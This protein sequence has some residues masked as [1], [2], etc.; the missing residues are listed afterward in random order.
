MPRLIDHDERRQ[1]FAEATWRVILRDGVGKVSVRTVAAEAGHSAGSLRHVFASQ[2]ELLVFALQLVV[3]RAEERVDSLREVP[4]PFE[5]VQA[6][7]AQLLPLDAQ[8]RAEMEVYLALFTAAN[9]DADLRPARDVAHQSVLAGC[10]W[11]I[12]Q[13]DAGGLLAGGADHEVEARRLHALIDGLAAHLI[14]EAGDADPGWAHEVLL[15]HL[16]SLRG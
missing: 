11:M 7:A 10:R 14:Y 4:G 1:A 8:R 13:L 2:S 3:D 6:V 12:E 9:A 16:A 5:R 15:R